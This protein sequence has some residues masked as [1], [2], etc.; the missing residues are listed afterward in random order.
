MGGI[1]RDSKV[2]EV[3]CG[4]GNYI[5]ALSE[6]TGALG[7]GLDPS[8]SMLAQARSRSSRVTFRRGQAERLDYPPEFFDL[9]FSVDVIHHVAGRLEYLEEAYRVLKPGGRLCTVTDSEGVIRHRQPLSTY[10]PETV[11]VELD[12]YPRM[13]DL[14]DMMGRVGFSE[15]A[16]ELVE[17]HYQLK[18]VQAYR[19]R[20][21]S[22]LHLI[23]E[24]AFQRGI[25]RMERDLWAGPIPCVARYVLLWGCKT[26]IPFSRCD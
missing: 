4:T 18:D 2:L 5:I 3:G 23:A 22:S 14:R 6:L 26:P 17:L 24:E 15:V 9:V 21:F 16:E 20:A 10:F 1:C 13:A 19:D 11:Q 25:E 12:R 7:W 8:E